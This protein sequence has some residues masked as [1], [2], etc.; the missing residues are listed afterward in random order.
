MEI[1]ENTIGYRDRNKKD[2]MSAETWEKIK[3]RK[4]KELLNRAKTRNQKIS[5]QAE[6]KVV[7]KEVK[8]S[9]RN[10]KR[11]WIEQQAITAE[12]AAKKG[13]LKQ[14]YQT[15][16]V[17]SKQKFRKNVP[18]KDKSGKM[19][20]NK[21]EQMERWKQH[22]QEILNRSENTGL[23]RNKVVPTTEGEAELELEEDNSRQDLRISDLPPTIEE[24]KLALKQQK[25]GKAAAVDQI[26]PEILKQD[27][28]VMAE[29]LYRIF[30]EVWEREKMPKDCKEGL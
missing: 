20:T 23:D 21:S 27:T 9:A 1:S 11:C 8:Q 4:H 18:V 26:P 28:N 13:D 29:M 30:T 16:R 25:N 12:E 17:L 6:Y 15:T 2:W 10:D 3:E 7:D 19:L 22:F 5:L 14:L 24:I